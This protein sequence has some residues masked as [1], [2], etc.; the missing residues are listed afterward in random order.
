MTSIHPMSIEIFKS[1]IAVINKLELT[2]LLINIIM[3][4]MIKL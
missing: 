4:L 1:Q 3:D 2:V